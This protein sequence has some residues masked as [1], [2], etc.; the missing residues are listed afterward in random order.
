[1]WTYALL[2]SCVPNL[3]QCVQCITRVVLLT[4]VVGYK[5]VTCVVFLTLVVVQRC[6]ACCVADTGG[7]I[8]MSQVLCCGP[9]RCY[10]GVT[11]VMLLTL[12]VLQR[13]D[14]SGDRGLVQPAGPHQGA[15]GGQVVTNVSLVLCC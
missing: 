5:G 15:G 14:A 2:P 7:D 4:L 9:W 12:A 6:H 10:K 1:M 3:S 11:C 8:R 13:C